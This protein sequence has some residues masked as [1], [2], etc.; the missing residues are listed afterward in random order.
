MDQIF[1]IKGDYD[2]QILQQIVNL[3][4]TNLAEIYS[5]SLKARLNIVVWNYEQ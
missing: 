5:P 3:I 2:G 4:N 1:D